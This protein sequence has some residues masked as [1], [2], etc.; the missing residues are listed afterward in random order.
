MQLETW[1]EARI[2]V[3]S[4]TDGETC[5]DIARLRREISRWGTERWKDKWK[6]YQDGLPS[7]TR[8]PAQTG[9]LYD[10]RLGLYANMPKA[11][12]S[13]AVQLRTGKI[14]LRAFLYK[15]RVPG[16]KSTGCEC[17]WRYQ[18]AHHML[19]FCP[20]HQVG[21]DEMTKKAGTKDF[22]R[23]VA[24]SKGLG[25]ATEWI[26]QR[27]ILGQYSLAKEQLFGPD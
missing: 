16:I 4:S 27:G 22:R 20:N 24:T 12:S 19:I 1:E 3:P 18:D 10:E 14:G 9:A 13:V 21:R 26:I 25:A 11:Q 8:S 23:I 7:Y 17:G 2:L 15:R 6:G 5:K